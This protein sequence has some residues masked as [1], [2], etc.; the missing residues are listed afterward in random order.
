MT[1]AFGLGP[2]AA[3]ARPS[4]PRAMVLV[5]IGAFL[6][7]AVN[8][9]VRHIAGDMHPF[10]ITF[11]R[12]LFGFLVLAPFFV[13]RGWAPFRTRRLPLHCVRAAIHALSMILLVTGITLTPI[14][15]VAALVFTS[16][17]FITVMAVFALGEVLRARRISALL[18]GFAGTLVIV[19]PGIAD[20]D[21]GALII[22]GASV[23]F[24][25]ITIL[26]KVLARTESPVTITAYTALVSIVITGV[27]AIP[28]WQAPSPA[29]LGWLALAGLCGS[30]NHLCQ[31]QA[32]KEAEVTAILPVSYTMLIFSAI[33]GYAFFAEVPD[34]W[35][36]MGGTM[37][38]A[39]ACYIAYRERRLQRSD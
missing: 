26:L 18:F 16:P 36:W 21:V 12:F 28:V 33:L 15:K 23:T 14:A 17:L 8:A 38:F 35:T 29:H 20:F 6:G 3:L 25:L 24:A 2:F 19:R 1:T 5:T 9:C 11:F 34:V 22:L 32:F 39:S 30:L 7:S 4:T 37:I 27:V 13:R 31:A 10:E